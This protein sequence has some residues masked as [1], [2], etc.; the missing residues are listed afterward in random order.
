MRQGI[1]RKSFLP[2]AHT[3][4]WFRQEAYFPADVIDRN[5]LDEWQ[6]QG[7]KDATHRA[8]ERVEKLIAAHRSEP[9]EAAIATHLRE[10]MEAEAHKFGMEK[11]PP[12]P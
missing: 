8:A 10:V 2:L 12:L 7:S 11:L 5:A 9:L 4:Q 6:R 3:K 1:D